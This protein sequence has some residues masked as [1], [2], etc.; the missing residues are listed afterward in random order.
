[1]RQIFDGALLATLSLC[2]LHA[3]TPHVQTRYT[4]QS[5]DVLEV[6]FPL[7]PEYGQTVTVDPTGQVYLPQLGDLRAAGMTVEQFRAEI[8][9][10]ASRHL[11]NPEVSVNL[12]DF[13][14]P[15][16]FVEGEVA[17][18]G[19]FE[20]RPD[21]SV[22]DAVALA[23]GFKGSARK[24]KVL[25]LRKVDG[26]SETK[27]LNLKAIIDR[28]ELQEAASLKPGDVIFVTQDSLSKIERIAR[29]GTFGAIYNPLQ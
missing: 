7:T 16:F 6:R 28:G 9:A 26:S 13:D 12:K 17:T 23:G 10:A 14:K 20:Y 5:N 27:I 3:Q 19:K 25:L 4:I 1:M 21:I 29:L 11:V 8:V 15:H 22:L 2:T 18:P 24:S